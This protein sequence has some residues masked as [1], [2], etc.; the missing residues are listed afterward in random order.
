MPSLQKNEKKN[1]RYPHGKRLSEAPAG[2]PLLRC[3]MEH[4]GGADEGGLKKVE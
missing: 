1:H 3:Q 4:G 2:M